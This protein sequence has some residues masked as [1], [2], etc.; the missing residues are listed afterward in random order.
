[1]DLLFLG[2]TGII[3]S[4]CSRLALERGHRLT[5]LNRGTSLRPPA[6]GAE[7]LHADLRD[8]AAV[9]AALGDRRFDAIV[10]WIAFTPGHV[11]TALELWRD[12]MAQ[13]VFIS[14]A[15]AYQTPPERLPVTEATPLENPFWAYSR[16]KI[17]CE[18]R[19]GRAFRDHVFPVTIVR[20]SHTY[21]RTLVPL[22]GGWTNVE[23]M[24]TGR[25]IVVHGDGSSLWTLTHHAD[26]AVGLVGLLGN[27][28]AIGEVYH[29]TSDE[30]LSW[31]RIAILMGRAAGAEPYLVHVPSHVIARHDPRWGESLLGD[32]TH[33][34][35]FDN[36]KIR[37]AVPDF[38]PKIPFEQGAREIV[39]WYDEHPA[40]RR[41]DPDFDALLDRLA[42]EA[43]A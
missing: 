20:P 22:H 32:K 31:D 23:R 33:S 7:V 26:F 37:A 18:E 43:R 35:V 21:D 13:Y 8:P 40:R 39:A 27:E 41:V 16:D 12:R 10:D 3:S 36:A 9:R 2:G 6:E 24:R 5:L 11:E 25:P 15:S 17:A 42:A 28:R 38:R 14:S 30:W 1:M 34:M 4:A 19:L 29:I